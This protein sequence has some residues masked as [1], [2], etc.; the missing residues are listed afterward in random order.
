M[1]TTC[2][3]TVLNALTAP[4][5]STPHCQTRSRKEALSPNVPPRARAARFHTSMTALQ[6][7]FSSEGNRTFKLYPRRRPPARINSG[8]VPWKEQPVWRRPSFLFLA[9]AK[10]LRP[11]TVHCCRP[12]TGG[13][14]SKNIRSSRTWHLHVMAS[15]CSFFGQGAN[16]RPSLRRAIELAA[17]AP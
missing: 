3:T 10:C 9:C 5:R 8:S 14:L 13:R 11:R 4:P 6:R 16:R 7:T 17:T 15:A 2:E 1:T 12:K